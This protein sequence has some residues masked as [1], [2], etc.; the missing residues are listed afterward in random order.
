VSFKRHLIEMTLS[1]AIPW[2]AFFLVVHFLL[3]SAGLTPAWLFLMPIA[4]AVMVVPMTALMLYRG[5]SGRD[6]LEMNASMFAG[7]LVVIPLA[8]MVLPAMGVQ[9]G[10]A[11]IFPIALVAMTAPMI[12]LMY[13]RREHHAHHVH[14]G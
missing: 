3:P 9:L 4:I 6:I 14:A 5:H 1:M 7:M 12:L 10:L 2:S 8:R 13:V 11:E